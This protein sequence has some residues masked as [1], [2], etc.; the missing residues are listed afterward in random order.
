MRSARA[1]GYV[2]TNYTLQVRDR[3]SGVVGCFLFDLE[4]YR[5]EGEFYAVGEVFA[6]LTA[7]YAGTQPTDRHSCYVEY[8]GIDK[9]AT[10]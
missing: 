8:E 10:A 9:T 5:T 3:V 1:S 2:T 7:L 6:D 4:K